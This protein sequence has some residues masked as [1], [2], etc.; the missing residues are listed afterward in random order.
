MLGG[1]AGRQDS[2]HLGR[3]EEGETCLGTIEFPVIDL[4][5]EIW[6]AIAPKFPYAVAVCGLLGDIDFSV[7]FRLSYLPSIIALAG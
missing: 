2:A 1:K 7:R 4:A 3:T 6:V 5:A